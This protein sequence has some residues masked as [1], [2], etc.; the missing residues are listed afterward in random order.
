MIIPIAA[1]LYIALILGVV[2]FHVA[3]IAGAPWGYLTQGGQH[4]GRL[5]LRNRVAAG[6]SIALL[7]CMGAAI[8]S[9]AGFAPSAPAWIGWATVGV[10]ALSTLANWATTSAPERRL[11]A[12]INTV[13]LA[14]ALCVVTQA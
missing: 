3:L 14:A 4:R 7:L 13:M 12:P 2:A 10:Q 1:G 11:W 8:A 9:T 6:V 5:P